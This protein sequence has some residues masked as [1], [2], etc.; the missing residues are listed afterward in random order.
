M[1]I[2][3][4]KITYKKLGITFLLLSYAIVLTGFKQ[5][6]TEPSLSKKVPIIPS[7]PIISPTDTINIPLE[8]DI[9][10]GTKA[11]RLKKPLPLNPLPL[12]SPNPLDPL[13]EL[14]TKQAI[15][16]DP[17]VPIIQEVRIGIECIS[18]LKN[19]WNLVKN[20]KKY[21]SN[22][23]YEYTGNF[24]I[25]FRR[26]IKLTAE[27]GYAILYPDKLTT[28]RSHYKSS[29]G[30]GS[31]ELAYLSR[32][33]KTENIYAGLR[34]SRAYFTNRT[35]PSKQNI[36]PVSKKL[37]ASWFELVIGTESLLLEKLNIYGGLMLTI[38]YLQHYDIFAPAKDYIIPGY[39][40]NTNKIRPAL[41]LYIM[42]K[43]CFTERMIKFI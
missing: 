38:G 31:L 32:Y 25:L 13:N 19:F 7:A 2:H 20:I 9:L 8:G 15:T 21:E 5:G 11:P 24:S 35:L 41:N 4:L 10:P 14:I 37:S 43:L 27:G 12:A 17:Y 6:Y 28:N 3:L 34:Y 18:L 23:P 22:R 29:G 39:G 33:N 30:Y 1:R 36:H 42:Y 16:L 26:N 40:F